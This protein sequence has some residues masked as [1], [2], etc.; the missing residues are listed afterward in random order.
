MRDTSFIN[1]LK[2]GDIV[3][4]YRKGIHV[5]EKITRRFIIADDLR[6]SCNKGKNVGDEAN[7]LIGYRQV[8]DSKWQTTISKTI[9]WCD[10][11]FCEP[12]NA[13]YFDQVVAKLQAQI[14]EVRRF[15][16]SLGT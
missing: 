12:V 3:T 6:F 9:Y 8:A 7:S 10:E 4:A 2:V 16:A 11:G 1:K 14:N 15:Q 13:D 5:I